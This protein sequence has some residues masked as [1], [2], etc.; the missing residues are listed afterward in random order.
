M[1]I[2]TVHVVGK[3]VISLSLVN[4]SINSQSHLKV[5]LYISQQRCWQS[6]QLFTDTNSLTGLFWNSSHQ[7]KGSTEAGDSSVFLSIVWESL[8]VLF[9]GV[10]EG[11][12]QFGLKTVQWLSG[13]RSVPFTILTRNFLQGYWLFCPNALQFTFFGIYVV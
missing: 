3:D 7:P 9:T 4:M 13:S 1:M 5:R 8:L 6:K 10:D 12:W 11:H 2:L